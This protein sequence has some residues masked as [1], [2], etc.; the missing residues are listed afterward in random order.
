MPVLSPHARESRDAFVS[1]FMS[2]DAMQKEFPTQKQRVAVAMSQWRRKA[3]RKHV[4]TLYE[5]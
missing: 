1:R 5:S 4:R 2:S 3:K